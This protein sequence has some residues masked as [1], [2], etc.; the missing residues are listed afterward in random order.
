MAIAIFE[1]TQV[2]GKPDRGIQLFGRCRIASGVQAKRMAG[3]YGRR[4]PAFKM[5]QRSV[6]RA[7]GSF[8]L[9]AYRFVPK[10]LTLFDER[11][12][13]EGVF[14]EVPVPRTLTVRTS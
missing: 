9:R 6:E 7:E 11:T 12:F 10:S 3:L 14:V 5:W 4:F 2:W 8:T 1:S 13:G